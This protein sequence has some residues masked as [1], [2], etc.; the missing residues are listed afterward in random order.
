MEIDFGKNQTPVIDVVATPVEGVSVPSITGG[1]PVD[2]AKLTAGGQTFS[3]PA[4]LADATS[5][6]V[7]ATIGD[8]GFVM[9][10]HLPG[11]KDIILPRVNI[12]Q[13]VGLLKDSFPQGAIV[14]NQDFPLFTLPT[15][16][17]VDTTTGTVVVPAR[18]ATPP[19][20][21]T[22]LGFRPTRFVENVKGGARGIICNTE[23]QVRANGGTLD[24]NEFKLKEAS[25][26]KRFDTLAEAFVIIRR[27]DHVKDDDTRFTF[28]VDG[29]KY[30]LALWAMKGTAYTHAAKRVFFT[31]RKMG[32]L[33]K[34]GYPSWNYSIS[35]RSETN[36]GNTYF[37]PVCLPCAPNTPAFLDFVKSILNP[38]PATASASSDSAE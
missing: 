22:V 13:G 21:M 35:T 26:M 16:P 29:H 25:G 9:G 11:F 7:P 31:A 34:G 3:S 36:K 15:Q 32:C 20:N 19:V 17:I 27:P 18:P 8:E 5:L 24:Y 2:P 33:Q 10:D 28:L 37:V 6:G 12:V 30:A 1:G 14:Y 4:A 38:A 23:E